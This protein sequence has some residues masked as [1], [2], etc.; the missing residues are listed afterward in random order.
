M[1]KTTSKKSKYVT[2]AEYKSLFEKEQNN[3]SKFSVKA[4][5]LQEAHIR[6]N[7]THNVVMSSYSLLKTDFHLAKLEHKITNL[8]VTQL[9]SEKESHNLLIKQL[10]NLNFFQ[11]LWLITRH[12]FSEILNK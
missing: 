6:L 8:T 10:N 7:A 12:S 2:R 1:S 3:S 5:E 9:K 11:K 4:Q